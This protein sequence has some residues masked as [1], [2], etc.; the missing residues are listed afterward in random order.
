MEKDEA[1]DSPGLREHIGCSPNGI[2]PR[3]GGIST[4]VTLLAFFP[5]SMLCALTLSYIKTKSCAFKSEKTEISQLCLLIL[6]NIKEAHRQYGTENWFLSLKYENPFLKSTFHE[7]V[8]YNTDT[9]NNE[10]NIY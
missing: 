8:H 2:T 7:S 4:P 9:I 6:T 3:K 10:N 1:H 5:L